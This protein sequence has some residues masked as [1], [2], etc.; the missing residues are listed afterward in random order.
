[1]RVTL[2]PTADLFHVGYGVFSDFPTDGGI[3]RV[4]VDYEVDFE[5]IVP[6]ELPMWGMITVTN[7]D[8]QAI[9]T[10]TPQP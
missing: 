6:L 2:P 9:S 5:T 4:T 10:I 1:V 8:T 3:V 7:N